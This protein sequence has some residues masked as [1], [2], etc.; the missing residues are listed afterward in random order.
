MVNT[1]RECERRNTVKIAIC[2]DEEFWIESLQASVSQWA[3]IQNIEIT[4]CKFSSPQT[5]IKFLLNETET[6]VVFL[7]I[8]F[9]KEPIDGMNAAKYIRK[10]GNRIPIIFVTV[11]QVRAA[12]GYLVEAMGFLS[13]PIDIKRLT[14]FLDRVIENQKSERCLKI[15][16]GN[17]IVNIR[18]RDIVFVEVINHTLIYHMIDSKVECRGSL[19]EMLNLWG[20]DCFVQIHR[21]YVIS[22]EKIYNIKTTYPYSV[23]VLIGIE[24]KN[25]SVSRK[26]KDKLLEVYSDDVLGRIL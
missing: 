19:S 2:E 4:Y 22:K 15:Q 3:K 7:D 1:L 26:Y 23:N 25:L 10:M 13:K 6:E 21:S 8:S 17:E 14:L 20:S 11:D 16:T 18:Q 9:E 24:I 12:D 5:L